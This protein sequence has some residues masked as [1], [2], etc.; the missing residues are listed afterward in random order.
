MSKFS[1]SIEKQLKA[2]GDI[3]RN[4]IYKLNCFECGT[5]YLFAKEGFSCMCEVDQTILCMRCFAKR[6]IPQKVKAHPYRL[7]SIELIS[8][9]KFLVEHKK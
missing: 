6:P 7:H 8:F 2:L 5:N 9:A 1:P 4:A 3:E